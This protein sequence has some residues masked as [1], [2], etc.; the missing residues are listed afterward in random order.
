MARFFPRQKHNE[1][2]FYMLLY[3]IHSPLPLKYLQAFSERYFFSLI[4]RKCL[5]Q[6]SCSFT[7]HTRKVER[8]HCWSVCH[9]RQGEVGFFHILM[10][11]TQLNMMDC[12]HSF[13]EQTFVVIK[14]TFRQHK[15]DP[16]TPKNG[17]KRSCSS[18]F[19]RRRHLVPWH[20]A[21][22]LFIAL[23]KNPKEVSQLAVQ[24]A[25]SSCNDFQCFWFTLC[26]LSFFVCL[27][28]C[29]FVCFLFFFP[30]S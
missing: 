15:C 17:K 11:W 25:Y 4:A 18:I 9:I 16:F 23:E 30:L 10:R 2:K 26:F 22:F 5:K 8:Y 1:I 6:G 19:F 7:G 14:R 29:L 13:Q 27:G 20:A 12:T 24:L 21:A 28:F 3:K